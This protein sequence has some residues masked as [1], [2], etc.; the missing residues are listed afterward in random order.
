MD[1]PDTKPEEEN[2]LASLSFSPTLSL[3]LSPPP[4]FLFH[5]L[6]LFFDN[7]LPRALFCSAIRYF[8]PGVMKFGSTEWRNMCADASDIAFHLRYF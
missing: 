2:S 5:T 3:S 1:W 6:F 8:H 7:M 4:S